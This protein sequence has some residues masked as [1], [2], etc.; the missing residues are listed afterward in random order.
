MIQPLRVIQAGSAALLLGLAACASGNNPAQGTGDATATAPVT[1]TDP[2]SRYL[3]PAAEPIGGVTV[4]TPPVDG[5]WADG[6]TSIARP[7]PG[8]TPQGGSLGSPDG[9]P[10]PLPASGALPAPNR[11]PTPP[12]PPPLR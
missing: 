12:P 3:D 8:S 5:A 9:A 6:Q 11:Y 1:T 7:V 10:A 4:E 2:G